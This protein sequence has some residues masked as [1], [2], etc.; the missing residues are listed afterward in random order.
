MIMRRVAELQ[1]KPCSWHLEFV[2]V[3]ENCQTDYLVLEI[4]STTKPFHNRNVVPHFY[5]IEAKSSAPTF[6]GTKSQLLH[7]LILKNSLP[8]QVSTSM[9]NLTCYFSIRVQFHT[10]SAMSATRLALVKGRFQSWE[11]SLINFL[12]LLVC[13]PSGHIGYMAKGWAGASCCRGLQIQ[14]A[15]SL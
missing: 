3:N 7:I 15:P 6:A 14:K 9:S 11:K 2:P 5:L 8:R 4:L 1:H 13:F 10:S 12:E